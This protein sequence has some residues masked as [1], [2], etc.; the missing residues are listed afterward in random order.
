MAEIPPLERT[1]YQRA[2]RT[3]LSNP[4]I[5]QAYPGPDA[6]PL[7]RR[8]ATS[9]REDLD[10][11][12]GYRLELTPTTARLIRTRDRLDDS[13][14]AQTI[15]TPARVFDRKRYAYLC[16]ALAVLGRSG[17]QLALTELAERVAAETRRVDGLELAPDK[18]ADRGAFVDA[19]AWLELR[20]AMRLADGSARRWLDDPSA[21]EALYDID[22][23]VIRA[24]YRPSRVLQHI[25]SVT[26]LLDRP[27][28]VS[29][30][31]LRRES[32]QRVRRALVENPVVYYDDLPGPDRGQLRN[33]GAADE[34]A[35]LTGLVVER[36]AEGV[37]LLDVSGSFSDHRFP[38]PGTVSQ[39]AL[40]LAN[41]IADRVLD[42]D[43]PVLLTATAPQPATAGLA[44]RLDTALPNS[45]VDPELIE[46]AQGLDTEDE[47]PIPARFP[48]VESGWL[49]TTVAELLAD[50]G[51]TFAASWA[52]D[53]DRLLATALTLLQE[54]RLLTVVPGGALV[55][56]LLARYRNA[57]ITVSPR[58]KPG[59][60]FDL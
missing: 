59:G 28:A 15:G 2:A 53:P 40:L 60:L 42:P 43:A 55:L 46:A 44:A 37:A 51:H 11:L 50:Y 35:E 17:P 6:L 7:I 5:T 25:D 31:T 8:W 34:V 52:A 20:G 16:L 29:R 12:L 19:V 47:E 22:R 14:P 21:G 39:V 56:P 13:Q 48:L 10:E 57:V 36:R 38:A 30:T 45:G 23:D 1:A 58:E 24:L 33:P 41:R 4:F 54:L 49:H 32:A 18:A 27:Q 3:L 9:L 26:A